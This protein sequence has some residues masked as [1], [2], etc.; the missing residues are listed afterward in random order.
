VGR[1]EP[2]AFAE[3]C[4]SDSG[5]LIMKAYLVVSVAIFALVA[6]G[7]FMRIVQG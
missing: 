5:E 2:G 4:T 1:I 3:H 7:H 6:V